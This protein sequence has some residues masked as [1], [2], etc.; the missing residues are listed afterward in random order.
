M[1]VFKDMEELVRTVRSAEEATILC[2]G[3]DLRDVGDESRLKA[4]ARER[5]QDKLRAQGLVALPEVPQYQQDLAY[6]SQ[7][8]SMV[9]KVWS[10][11]DDP[12]ESGLRI[13]R[14]A[15]GGSQGIVDQQGALHEAITAIEEAGKA[16]ASVTNGAGRR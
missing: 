4:L 6:V 14:G 9:D 15:A 5:I 8:G 10:A 12:G 11:L 2:C 13:L 3:E 1:G 7:I 16:L